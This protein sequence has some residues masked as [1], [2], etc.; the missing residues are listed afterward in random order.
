[1][2]ITMH[3]LMTAD[4][5]QL[6][7]AA[8]NWT[9]LVGSIDAIVDD[10]GRDTRELPN[11]WT[12]SGAVA[13]EAEGSR[14]RAQIG[15]AH[16]YC[17]MIKRQVRYFADEV[18]SCQDLLRGVVGDAALN[19]YRID[20]TS[21]TITAPATPP[22]NAPT[23]GYFVDHIR[24]ILDR[25]DDADRRTT[26]YMQESCLDEHDP[27]PDDEMAPLDTLKLSA[28]PMIGTDSQAD[29]W[30]SQH[31]LNQE[32]AIN[33]YPEII[34]GNEGFPPDARDKANRILLKREKDMLLGREKFL[35]GGRAELQTEQRLA[36]IGDLERRL[37]DGYLVSYHPG[38]G[39]SAVLGKGATETGP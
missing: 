1:M 33:E 37:G 6:R 21:G 19:G 12:G 15:N 3:G 31:P 29:F 22:M 26:Q 11:H 28:L 14:L 27:V 30:E 7:A 20:V 39:E 13:A 17:D 24:E 35:D 23:V 18:E 32:K 5:A 9:D 10:L 25:V 38:S 16:L 8:A 34:G 2:A 4:P 36:E